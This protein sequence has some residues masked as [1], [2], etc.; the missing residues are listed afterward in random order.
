[1]IIFK[2]ELAAD[3]GINSFTDIALEEFQ[4]ACKTVS[5]RTIQELTEKQESGKGA[6]KRG[7]S[8]SFSHVKAMHV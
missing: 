5:Q 6:A 1:M 8:E 4:E 3:K 2:G 7:A